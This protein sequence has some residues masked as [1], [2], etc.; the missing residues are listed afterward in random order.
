MGYPGEKLF[1]HFLKMLE[2]N[3]IAPSIAP[4]KLRRE[5]AAAI[6]VHRAQ[7][8]AVAQTEMDISRIQSGECVVVFDGGGTNLPRLVPAARPSSGVVPDVCE[9]PVSE[10][11]TNLAI[12]TLRK[13]LNVART[14]VR[15]GAVLLE[16]S[17]PPPSDYPDPDWL[18]RWRENASSVSA[19]KMQGLWAQVL[20][21]EVRKP[22]SLSLRALDLLKN[23]DSQ[24][25]AK[26]EK[27]A[28]FVVNGGLVYRSSI[29]GG[30][31]SLP[32]NLALELQELGMLAGVGG[33][34]M[35]VKWKSISP[36]SFFASAIAIGYSLRITGADPAQLVSLQGFKVTSVGQ[37]ILQLVSADGSIDYIQELGVAIKQQGFEVNLVRVTKTH[38]SEE[39]SFEDIRSL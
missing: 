33:A 38:G 4:W 1:I 35:A 15:A 31:K 10:A 19:E 25:A 12:R 22:G 3:G 21:R 36:T 27:L 7:M 2:R 6:D 18:L 32:F 37:E 9:S 16:G 5:G 14:L 23:L 39:L 30:G 20:A 8:L 28:P 24:D 34:A 13:E 29:P 17:E 11:F 26:I